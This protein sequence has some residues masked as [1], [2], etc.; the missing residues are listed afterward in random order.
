MIPLRSLPPLA[1]TTPM[2]ETGMADAGMADATTL[3]MVLV[4]ALAVALAWQ[5]VKLSKQP[6]LKEPE[7]RHLCAELQNDAAQLVDVRETHECRQ[8]MFSCAVAYPLS[9]ICTQD[10]KPP[11]LHEDRMTYVYC[12]DGRR[13]R[14]AADALIM[15]GFD[16]QCVVALSRGFSHLC[17]SA[18][19]TELEE[20][21]AALLRPVSM[22]APVSKSR[23]RNMKSF[24]PETYQLFHALQTSRDYAEYEQVRRTVEYSPRALSQAAALLTRRCG[25]WVEALQLRPCCCVPRPAS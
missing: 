13:A 18:R 1:D 3:A 9:A 10:S 2:N 25:C 5:I 11:E 6:K 16:S 7:W 17:A 21:D 19:N 8:G 15:L 20:S 4:P 23:G 22:A 12:S 14:L 24:D